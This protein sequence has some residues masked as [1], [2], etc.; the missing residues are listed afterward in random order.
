M[1]LYTIIKL[2]RVFVLEIFI[3]PGERSDLE[4]EEGDTFERP[5]HGVDEVVYPPAPPGAGKDYEDDSGQ[6]ELDGGEIPDSNSKVEVVNN[7]G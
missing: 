1:V 6:F 3:D 2:L 7:Y 5:G 4:T